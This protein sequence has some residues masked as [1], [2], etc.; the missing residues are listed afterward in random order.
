MKIKY[1]YNQYQV[2]Y[3]LILILMSMKKITAKIIIKISKEIKINFLEKLLKL[4]LSI[5][6]FIYYL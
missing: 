1:T 6:N 5:S 3:K 4:I 2:D